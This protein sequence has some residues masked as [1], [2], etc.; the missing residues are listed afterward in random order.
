[1][2]GRALGGTMNACV[3]TVLT[4]IATLSTGQAPAET[5]PPP[6][7]ER[8]VDLR[9]EPFERM[10]ILGESTVEGGPWLASKRHR[11]ADVL[12][13]LISKTQRKRLKYYN[14]GIGANAISP[15][16][17]GYENSRKPSALERYKQD[18]IDRDPDLFILCYGLNDMRAGMP[19]EEFREDMSTI[20]RDVKSACDPV[21]V[22]TT[23][24]Y[25]TG[26]KSY[27][28]YDKGS[29]ELTLQYNDCIRGLAKEY[30]C[31]LADVW[32][33]EGGAD[34]LIDPDGVHANRA[35]N[36]VIAHRIFESIAQRASC[37]GQ[38]WFERMEDT[39]WRTNTT[40]AR[41]QSG[42]PFVK[43]WGNPTATD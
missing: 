30:G 37:L 27:P 36:L 12:A 14:A 8:S 13:K 42:D 28:P 11:Y 41:A 23:V 38:P 6:E 32:Q 18:V 35:G 19:I 17:P 29:V 10:V 40:R 15:R 21:I 33:A 16:S 25:M 24:Y 1:M 2:K 9:P 43:T 39:R 26:W 4:I 31:I 5:A 3:Y 20:I 7:F 34:W 22:L